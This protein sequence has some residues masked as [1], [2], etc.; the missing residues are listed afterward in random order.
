MPDDHG[1]RNH[2][3]G[4]G[5]RGEGGEGSAATVADHIDVVADPG[6]EVLTLHIEGQLDIATI[7]RCRAMLDVALTAIVARGDDASASSAL[8]TEAVLDLSELTFLSAGG[9]RLVSD[10]A[11]VLADQGIATVLAVRP[12]SLVSRLVHLPG[13]GLPT[14]IVDASYRH[15]A[16]TPATLNRDRLSEFRSRPE[17]DVPERPHAPTGAG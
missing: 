5:E 8:P 10:T 9:L 4:L 15:E 6:Q 2:R 17:P 3:S 12:D 7:R 1:P 14:P 11:Q 13:L 16:L